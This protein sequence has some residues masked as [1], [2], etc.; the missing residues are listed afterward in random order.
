MGQVQPKSDDLKFQQTRRHAG[1]E[2]CPLAVTSHHRR[3]EILKDDMSSY[4]ASFFR[5]KGWTQSVEQRTTSLW[6]QIAS[7]HSRLGLETR[8]PNEA[9]RARLPVDA[10]YKKLVFASPSFCRPLALRGLFLSSL[11]LLVTPPP[12]CL[13]ILF[14]SPSF[15]HLFK[16]KKK[17]WMCWIFLVALGLVALKHVGS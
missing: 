1:S 10:L 3:G 14:P 15:I 5:L 12:L 17:N 16:I 4:C 8:S 13:W 7:T 11:C 6:L 9:G 2:S